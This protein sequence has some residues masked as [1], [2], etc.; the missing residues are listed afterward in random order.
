MF[1]VDVNITRRSLR[2]R[3]LRLAV[4]EREERERKRERV[5]IGVNSE[6]S[7]L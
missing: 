4:S 5:R 1:S 7:V 3:F 6:K 2:H